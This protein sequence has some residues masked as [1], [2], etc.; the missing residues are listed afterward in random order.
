MIA[1]RANLATVV[2]V[3]IQ[4]FLGDIHIILPTDPIEQEDRQYFLN[5]NN[6]LE[7]TLN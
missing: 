7:I 1:Y 5:K 2:S 6:E 4:L 3:V